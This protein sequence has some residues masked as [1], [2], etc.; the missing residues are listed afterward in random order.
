MGNQSGKNSEFD[1]DSTES[2][3]EDEEPKVF[4]EENL[5]IISS[6]EPINMLQWSEHLEENWSRLM[7]ENTRLLV[8]A[9]VHG[10][11]DGELGGNEVKGKDNFVEDSERQVGRLTMKFRNGIEKKNIQFA[12]ID[13]GS[14]DRSGIYTWTLEVEDELNFTYSSLM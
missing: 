13:V 14:G 4:Q 8:L 2:D 10:K 11:E 6:K 12:V 7:K 5:V 9:G 3:S 1:S